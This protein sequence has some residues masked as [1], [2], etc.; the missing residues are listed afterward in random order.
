MVLKRH[1]LDSRACLSQHTESAKPGGSW[2]GWLVL[3]EQ[4]PTCTQRRA[5]EVVAA[6]TEQAPPL[7]RSLGN[8]RAE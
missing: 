8:H 2:P 7:T 3:M 6:Y 5:A 4:V 1:P